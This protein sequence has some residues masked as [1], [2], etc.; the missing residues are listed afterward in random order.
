MNGLFSGGLFLQLFGCLMNSAK[1]QIAV[2]YLP[3]FAGV[4]T[5]FGFESVVTLEVLLLLGKL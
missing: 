1:R 3:F 4:G 5:V 2:N